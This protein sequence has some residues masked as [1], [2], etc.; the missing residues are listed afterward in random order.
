MKTRDFL[1]LF[2]VD[3]T[4]EEAFTAINNVRGR[5][6]GEPGGD[7]SRADLTGL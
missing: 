3:Q 1:T 6:S 4:P 7:D 2:T 5:W